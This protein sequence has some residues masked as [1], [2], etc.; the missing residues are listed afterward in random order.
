MAEM[1]KLLIMQLHDAKN[2]IEQDR[3]IS[4]CREKLAN[5]GN[6]GKEKAGDSPATCS[7]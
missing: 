6:T 5:P 1:T 4:I 3:D 2:L 7:D